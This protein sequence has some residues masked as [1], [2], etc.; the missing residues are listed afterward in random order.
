[1][2]N[3]LLKSLIE[4][5]ITE[6]KDKHGWDD[7]FFGKIIFLAPDQR[8][9]IGEKLLEQAL[10]L[11]GVK[12]VT[13]EGALN[14]TEKHWDIRTE[15]MDI[16]VK[17]ATLGRNNNTFQHEN[18]EKDR[19]YDAVAF[20]DIGPNEIYLTWKAKK[21]LPFKTMHRRAAAQAYKED[22]TLSK[23]KHNKIE[24]LDDILRGYNALKLEL[25][26]M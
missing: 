19:Q 6:R 13:R 1:M 15:D 21:N 22:M 25:K 26:E 24:T 2:I 5:T 8:G 12:G 4:T 9:E 11:V 16:E 17:T 14:R 18:L 10:N 3:D 7:A 23:V 20:V